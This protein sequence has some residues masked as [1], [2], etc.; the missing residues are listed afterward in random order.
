MLISHLTARWTCSKICL[1]KGAST[2]TILFPTATMYGDGIVL[3]VQVEKFQ[4]IKWLVSFC[5]KK[6][7]IVENINDGKNGW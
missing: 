7:F 6:S 5:Q 3:V 4:Q 1:P 2:D